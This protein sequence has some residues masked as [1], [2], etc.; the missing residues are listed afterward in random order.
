MVQV[1]P[2]SLVAGWRLREGVN[3]GLEGG[4]VSHCART[5]VRWAEEPPMACSLRVR[6]RSGP[7]QAKLHPQVERPWATW[8]I[9]RRGSAPNLQEV[10]GHGSMTAEGKCPQT[11]VPHTCTVVGTQQLSTHCSARVSTHVHLELMDKSGVG[12]YTDKPLILYAY[13]IYV[14]T[15]GSSEVWG[16]CLHGHYGTNWEL[17]SHVLHL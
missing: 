16:G 2:Q 9:T 5:S 3:E 4:G 15:L 10:K 7:A 8:W 13:C 1:C 17:T 12:A 6:S 14:R 11:T